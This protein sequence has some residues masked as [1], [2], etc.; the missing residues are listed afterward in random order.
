MAEFEPSSYLG[1]LAAGI[2][3]TDGPLTAGLPDRRYFV[4]GGSSSD[5][6]MTTSS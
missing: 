2:K 5:P 3:N 1:K 4:F 6:K